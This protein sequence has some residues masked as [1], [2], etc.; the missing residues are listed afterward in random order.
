MKKI[1]KTKTIEEVIGYEAYD[2]THFEVREECEKYEKTAKA[3]IEMRIKPYKLGETSEWNFFCY[4]G[5]D[6]STVEVYSIPDEE[7]FDAL[8]MYLKN[9]ETEW[10]GTIT[11]P[12]KENFIG[13]NMILS[14]NYD[15]DYC[16]IYT[17]D[18]ILNEIRNSYEKVIKPKEENK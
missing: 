7:A 12:E 10:S 11:V 18:D 14:W 2:G 16:D 8:C 17:I 1:T 13:N 3:V 5:C 6:D 9:N 4:R 15:H